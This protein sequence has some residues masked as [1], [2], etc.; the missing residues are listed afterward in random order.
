MCEEMCSKF[1]KIIN[2][3]LH[4]ESMLARG[5]AGF[6]PIASAVKERVKGKISDGHGTEKTEGSFGGLTV[7]SYL[8]VTIVSCNRT[9][10]NK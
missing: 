4:L 1:V 5:V 2:L 10:Q 8:Y 9:R 6:Q 7:F 3:E